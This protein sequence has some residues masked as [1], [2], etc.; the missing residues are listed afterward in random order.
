MTDF[1]NRRT[2]ETPDRKQVDHFV[3]ALDGG[4]DTLLTAREGRHIAAIVEAAKTSAQ[5]NLATE[6]S[7][8]THDQ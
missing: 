2:D 1:R 8:K 4:I 6:V 5:S 3:G 7:R